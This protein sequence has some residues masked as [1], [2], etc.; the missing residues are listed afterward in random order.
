VLGRSLQANKIYSRKPGTFLAKMTEHHFLQ[1]DHKSHA[2]SL[3]C[4]RLL[5]VIFAFGFC[6]TVAHADDNSQLKPA[7]PKLDTSKVEQPSSSAPPPAPAVKHN[8]STL[9][10]KVEHSHMMTPPHN[11]FG[12]P[13]HAHGGADDNIY[14]N[15]YHRR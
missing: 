2:C 14:R 4:Q 5:S 12:L 7:S 8:P 1:L 10:G 9:Q 15:W 13:G 6:C 11:L 3:L